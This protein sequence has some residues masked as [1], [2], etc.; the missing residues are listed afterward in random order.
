VKFLTG[1]DSTSSILD[2]ISYA[3]LNLNALICWLAIVSAIC[4]HQILL[5]MNSICKHVAV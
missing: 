1:C 2:H 3:V 5:V 4:I